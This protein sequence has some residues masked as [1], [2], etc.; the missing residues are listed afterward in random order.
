M[1]KESNGY[2]NDWYIY[3]V[4]T[5][6]F[7]LFI[8]NFY[9]NNLKKT[10][11]KGKELYV[12]EQVYLDNKNKISVV[13]YKNNKFIVVIGPSGISISDKICEKNIHNA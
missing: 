9:K 5:L 6:I 12:E 10:K 4:L 7:L 2:I 1:F 13:N 8:I 3:I 11:H